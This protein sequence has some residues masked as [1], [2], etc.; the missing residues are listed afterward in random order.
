MF[1]RRSQAFAAFATAFAIAVLSIGT[2]S[3]GLAHLSS[4]GRQSNNL[5]SSNVG[6]TPSP[7]FPNPA[8]PVSGEADGHD[9]HAKDGAHFTIYRND[10]GEIVCRAATRE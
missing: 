9:P 8:G 3:A 4:N 7:T 2:Q 10:E 6:R 1:S 5:Q